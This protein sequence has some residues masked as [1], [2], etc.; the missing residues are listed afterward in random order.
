MKVK[1][2]DKRESI[3]GVSANEILEKSKEWNAVNE[4]ILIEDD[5]GNI[6]N[7]ENPQTLKSFLKCKANLSALEVGELYVEYL[8]EQELM[9]MNYVS[10][11]KVLE[12]KLDKIIELLSKLVPAQ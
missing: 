4:I 10:Q 3:N 1:I 2:W 12:A 11:E 6:T 8:K 9:T 5:Y 7:M